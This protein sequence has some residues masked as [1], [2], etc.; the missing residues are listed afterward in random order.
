MRLAC[1]WCMWNVRPMNMRRTIFILDK[2]LYQNSSIK[3]LFYFFKTSISMPPIWLEKPSLLDFALL[4]CQVYI[5]YLGVFLACKVKML[6]SFKFVRIV[7]RKYCNSFC[8]WWNFHQIYLVTRHQ[9]F[10]TRQQ[11]FAIYNYMYAT[12]YINYF[13]LHT[14]LIPSPYGVV[15]NVCTLRSVIGLILGVYSF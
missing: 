8:M 10:V 1:I 7:S 2:C 15:F 9:T 3:R 14:V 12:E 13:F 5:K 11:E 4:Y 6:T